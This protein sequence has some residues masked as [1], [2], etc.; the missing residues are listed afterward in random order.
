MKIEY[1]ITF[2]YYKDLAPAVPFYAD[3]LGLP[4]TVDQGW[5]KIFAVGPTAMVGLVDETHGS[6]KATPDKAVLLTLVVDDVDAWHG[7]LA[8][9]GVRNLTEPKLHKD[10]GVYCFFAED[11]GGYKLEF[12]RFV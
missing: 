6:L 11:P 10:I 7:K 4:L 12:Q 5:A 8:A 1:P 2:L 9:A 3:L